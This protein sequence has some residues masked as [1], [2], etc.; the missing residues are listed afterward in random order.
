M[1]CA[2]TMGYRTDCDIAWDALATAYN[3][4]DDKVF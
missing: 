1:D 4:P 2:W 3:D